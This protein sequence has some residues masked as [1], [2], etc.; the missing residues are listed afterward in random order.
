MRVQCLS[1]FSRKPVL[2]GF[3]LRPFHQTAS[4]WNTE[5]EPVWWFSIFFKF[6][7][8][9]KLSKIAFWAKL[10][11]RLSLLIHNI[12]NP[13]SIIPKNFLHFIPKGFNALTFYS[14]M[15]K[16]LSV[17]MT[18]C[19]KFIHFWAKTTKICPGFIPK[20]EIMPSVSQKPYRFFSAFYTDTHISLQIRIFVMVTQCV[21]HIPF[22]E[23]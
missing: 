7:E 5:W 23:K 1:R 17:F 16:N 4:K 18:K 10:K 2:Y 3:K 22:D 20:P 13:Y 8:K 14:K 9:F 15:L 6:E 21:L 19:Q 12:F 11:E